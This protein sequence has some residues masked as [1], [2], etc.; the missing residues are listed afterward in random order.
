M[1]EIFISLKRSVRAEGQVHGRKKFSKIKT[2]L[3]CECQSV[4][5]LGSSHL[6]L[7]KFPKL[8]LSRMPGPQTAYTTDIALLEA[9]PI[10]FGRPTVTTFSRA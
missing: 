5:P 2:L 10:P 9:L 3:Q 1:A 8:L 7:L 6:G 4:L